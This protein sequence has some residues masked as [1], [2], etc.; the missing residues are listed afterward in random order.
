MDGLIRAWQV[1]NSGLLGTMR[2]HAGWVRTLAISPDGQWLVSGGDDFTVRVWR[3]SSSSLLET[4][5]EGMTTIHQV[6]FAPDSK[7]Y[8]WAEESGAV[9][10]RRVNEDGS[11]N[12]Q[13]T[14]IAADCLAFLPDG[15]RLVAG[16]A[17]GS[18]RI[19]ST[20]DGALEQVIK[21][22]THAVTAL[23]VSTD[24]HWLVSGQ[25]NGTLGVWDLTVLSQSSAPTALLSGR[26][27]RV[28]SVDFSPL[29]D[30]IV[31][32]GEDGALQLW[33]TPQ[34]TAP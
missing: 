19:W 8:A 11:R 28:N 7:T 16:F 6:V 17:D 29:G 3:L 27:S 15:Q 24:G 13:G 1:V 10:L 34:T 26:L 32:G 12:F 20:D 33:A 31:S 9:R 14:A 18:I 21:I 25:D 2:G 5:D 23:A 30:L 4:I 22:D